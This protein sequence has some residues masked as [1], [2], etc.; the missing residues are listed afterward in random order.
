MALLNCCDFLV[1]MNKFLFSYTICIHVSCISEGRR[2]KQKSLELEGNEFV[3]YMSRIRNSIDFKTSF[4]KKTL[5]K[6]A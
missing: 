6:S 3:F 5:K 1:I 4:K 2:I